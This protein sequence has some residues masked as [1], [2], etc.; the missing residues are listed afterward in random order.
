MTKDKKKCIRKTGIY[1]FL[2][3]LLFSLLFAG[4]GDNNQTNTEAKENAPKGDDNS[5]TRE[6]KVRTTPGEEQKFTK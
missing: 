4:C 2:F 5:S 6:Q 1:N 3:I